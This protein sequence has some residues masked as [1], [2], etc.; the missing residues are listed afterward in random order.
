M[1]F[2]QYDKKE[3]NTTVGMPEVEAVEPIDE[4]SIPE[5]KPESGLPEDVYAFIVGAPVLSTPFAYAL[6]VIFIKYLV[7]S[8]LCMGIAADEAY[9]YSSP[10]KVQA[11]KFLLIPVAISMQEDLIHV[12]AY[13]ANLKYDDKVLQV[14]RDATKSKLILSMFLR[15]I[16]GLLSLS[17]NFLV[18]LQ[19]HENVPQVFL[20]FAAL[21]F[22]QSID[23]VFFLLLTKGFFGDG[24]EVM[25]EKCKQIV[26]PRRQTN[27]C[28]KK[29]DTVLFTLTFIVMVA[30]YGW[31]TSIPAPEESS[32]EV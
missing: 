12:Y 15:L 20:N 18:M 6:V 22:L 13:A 3:E 10:A 8:I 30:I 29:F 7:Y 11:V 17:V 24:M 1:A 16:D 26:F 28:V 4:N 31:V 32:E 19:T 25:T 23:D 2:V 14:S 5:E 9:F 27:G 21:H